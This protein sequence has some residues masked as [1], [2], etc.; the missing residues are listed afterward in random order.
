GT[1]PPCST[2]FASA[3]SPT[4]KRVATG[5]AGGYT[6]K[7]VNP[8]PDGD[9]L[10]A[11]PDVVGGHSQSANTEVDGGACTRVGV[12][13]VRTRTQ[14]FASVLG[15]YNGSTDSHSVARSIA[16]FSVGGVIAL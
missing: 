7:I 12:D 9:P 4:V 6:V 11:S 14:A 1:A 8:V 2:T 3:C 10:M 5:V 13:I 15:V 16:R